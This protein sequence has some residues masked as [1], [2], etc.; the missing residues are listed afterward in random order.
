MTF[1][2]IRRV[3]NIN[4][5]SEILAPIIAALKF[6]HFSNLKI[7]DDKIAKQPGD[8]LMNLKLIQREGYAYESLY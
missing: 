3:L 1:E 5:D 6:L 4:S 2:N 8:V 7:L